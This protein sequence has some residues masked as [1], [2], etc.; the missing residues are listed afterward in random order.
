VKRRFVA[1]A[2]LGLSSLLALSACGND[3]NASGGGGSGGDK[4][5]TFVAA[6]YSDA[7]QPYWQGVIKDFEA[8][9]PGYKVNLDVE[10]WNV[11]EDKV[12]NL[13][14]NHQQPDVLNVDHWIDFA[15]DDLLFKASDI[16][17]SQTQSDMLPGPVKIGTYK[18][19]QYGIPFILSTRLLY[20][21]KDLFSK[22]GLDP[23]KPPATWDELRAD[24]TKLKAAGVTEPYGMPLSSEEAQAETL[25]WLLGNGG[26]YV[27]ASGKWTINSP[28]NVEALTYMKSLVSAGLT[29]P[30][31]GSVDRTKGIFAD[32][33]A[34]HVGMMYGHMVPMNDI[35]AKKLPVNFGVAP[36][37]SKQA[38]QTSTLGVG[39]FI[40]GFKKDGGKNQDAV[41]KFMDF[42]FQ[43]QNYTKF[44]D[45]E[46]FLPVTQSALDAMSNDPAEANLKP[47]LSVLPKATFYPQ[48]DPAW[49]AVE[50]AIKHNIGTAVAGGNPQTVLDGIQQTAQKAESNGGG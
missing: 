50:D 10:N 29:E 45:G 27:D 32:F 38:G 19:T 49:P 40:M 34:G 8:A 18:G 42:V 36:G 44:L 11:I 4:T 1:T 5:I 41:H 7:T 48:T 33:E 47:F 22:A 30:N 46:K 21:N 39:D 23:N 28:Q 20:W 37:P 25:L 9:N 24:A 6:E 2:V 26:G 3:S 13:V 12:K 31:P 16:L 35:Q 43:K 14:Q 17:S 15:Q